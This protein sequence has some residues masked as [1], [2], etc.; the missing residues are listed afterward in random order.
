MK[1]GLEEALSADP[2]LRKPFLERITLLY[3]AMDETYRRVSDQY[4]FHCQGCE[5]SCCRTTFYHHTV[6]EALYLLAGFERMEKQLRAEIAMRA[7]SVSLQPHAGHFCPLCQEGRCLLY[8][9]R[10]MICRLHGI[11]HE[12]RRPD[13]TVSYG[14]GCAAFE[15]T[16]KGRSYIVFDRTEFYWTLSRMEQEARAALGVTNKLK[17]TISQMLAAFE[18]G[19]RPS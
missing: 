7:R 1:D 10:P 12:V 14:P 9:C 13:R 17:M 19:S 16:V 4:G 15:A 6:L 5:E 2:A 11:A 3:S 18:N 8:A